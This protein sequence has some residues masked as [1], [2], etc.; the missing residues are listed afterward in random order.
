VDGAREPIWRHDSLELFYRRGVRGTGLDANS[1]G[2]FGAAEGMFALR[3]DSARGVAT[4]KPVVLFQGRYVA[5]PAG[6]P[7]Y[8]VT[9]DGQR[10]I[11]VKPGEDELAPLRLNV[12]VNWADELARRVPTSFTRR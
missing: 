11:M 7:G 9:P 6:V 3:F 10:F 12:V 2:I 8:D 4:A 1:P 5:G